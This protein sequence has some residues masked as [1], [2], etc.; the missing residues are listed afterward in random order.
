MHKQP[1]IMIQHMLL[2][3]MFSSLRAILSYDFKPFT[4]IQY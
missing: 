4:K 1:L 3:A 2:H